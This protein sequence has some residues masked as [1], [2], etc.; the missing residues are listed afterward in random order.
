MS[1]NEFVRTS[2]VYFNAQSFLS[3]KCPQKSAVKKKTISQNFTQAFAD[4]SRLTCENWG[5]PRKDS[6]AE[7]KNVHKSPQA[8]TKART[9]ADF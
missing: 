5:R 7:W 6:P 2:A 9:F 8:L 1:A 4:V 3:P